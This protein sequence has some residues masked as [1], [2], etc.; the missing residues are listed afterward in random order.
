MKKKFLHF[1]YRGFD[2]SQKMILAAQRR[3]EKEIGASWFNS[4]KLNQIADYSVAPGIFN[5]KLDKTD[6]DWSF[7]L[8]NTLQQMDNASK[9]GFAFNI[10]SSDYDSKR[11]RTDLYYADPSKLT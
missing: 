8:Q 5:V 11:R 7:F 1:Q 10:L 3:F 6:F 2:I 4:A 9:L